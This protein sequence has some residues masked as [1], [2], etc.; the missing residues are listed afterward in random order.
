MNAKSTQEL[1]I[2]LDTLN[3]RKN[4]LDTDIA[5]TNGEIA[6]LRTEVT[7][8][9]SVRGD[10]DWQPTNRELSQIASDLG[11]N[12]ARL[13]HL[14]SEKANLEKD[15]KVTEKTLARINHDERMEA[16]RIKKDLAPEG[17]PYRREI[18]SLRRK[19]ASAENT[20]KNLKATRKCKCLKPVDE[21]PK[22]TDEETVPHL[23]P[24]F[25]RA[26]TA[27]FNRDAKPVPVLA[28]K[29]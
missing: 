14:N 16:Q 19:L 28:E 23:R 9:S 4:V 27:L 24:L 26:V 21:T 8:M 29:P 6:R 12:E 2:D 15:I 7:L 13:V 3:R 20:I 1:Q 5:F 25:Q 11:R 18:E 22:E 17:A 10:I